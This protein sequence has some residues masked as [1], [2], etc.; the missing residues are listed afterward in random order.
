MTR[1]SVVEHLAEAARRAGLSPV[2]TDLADV[3]WLAT[4][5]SPAASG[6]AEPGGPVEP[7]VAG[8]GEAGSARSGPEAG[9]SARPEPEP[10][11]A[12]QAGAGP[13]QDA[14][15]RQPAFEPPPAGQPPAG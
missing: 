9:V 2:A 5:I 12:D 6:V 11:Y 10:S 14:V 8:P 15:L 1:R 3:L 7:E 13:G 4:Q